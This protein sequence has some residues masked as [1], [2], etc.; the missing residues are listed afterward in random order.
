MH[1][2]FSLELPKVSVQKKL[3]SKENIHKIED[4]PDYTVSNH[5]FSSVK[6]VHCFSITFL[7]K[8]LLA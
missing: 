7:K 4:G 6:T 2:K 5:K 8:S 1:A 3:K